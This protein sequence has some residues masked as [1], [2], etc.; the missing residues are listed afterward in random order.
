MPPIGKLRHRVSLQSATT[1]NDSYGQPT[2]T[3]ATYATVWALVEPVSGEE[4]T[5]A[6]QLQGGTTHKI[7]IRY[8]AGVSVGHRILYGTRIFNIS[9][10]PRDEEERKIWLEI[11][12]E[13][14]Y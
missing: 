5:L 13:E 2:R 10:P 4:S 7:T 11:D 14:N 3:W 1:V 9:A 6:M 8:R 12:A